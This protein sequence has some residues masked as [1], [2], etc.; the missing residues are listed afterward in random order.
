MSCVNLAISFPIRCFLA[1]VSGAVYSLAYPP[2]GW[3]WLVLVGISGLL[4][5]LKDQR[6]SRARAIGFLHGIAAFS[7][8]LSWLFQIFGGVVIVLWMVLAAFPALFAE[9]Q[10]RASARGITGWKFAI[11]TAI[12]WGAWEWIRAEVFPLKFPWMSAGLAVGPNALLPWIGV[13]GVSL[14]VVFAAALILQKWKFAPIPLLV[15]AGAVAA[16]RAHPTP[17]A[18]DPKSVNTAGLQFENVTLDTYLTETRKLPDDVRYVVW[19]EYAVPYDIRHNKRDWE[20]VRTLCRERN[21]T[22][23]FG[24]QLRPEKGDEWENTALTVDANGILGEHTKIH[25]VHFF[26][27]GTPGRK[28]VPFQTAYGKVG[29]PICFDCDY[30]DVVRRMTKAGGEFL[31][32]PT[33]DAEKWTVRQHDQ[34]AELFRIRAAENGRWMLVAATSGITQMIDPH[35]QIHAR[36]D[37]LKQG[38]IIHRLR[39]ETALTFYTRLGWVLPWGVAGIAAVAWI[40]LIVIKPKSP[41]A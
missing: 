33:M 24:T 37:A 15:L 35:G 32:A 3:R 39:R 6:G 5:A 40:A 7:I 2:I 25:T 34:H 36:L 1:L 31:V 9:M 41:T 12:N 29:T 17:A 10:S 11:F 28:A 27:D 13:Y 26:D 20:L 23:T 4:L 38:T 30:E 21:L 19:P 16:F 8:G 14:I 18:D 22:L